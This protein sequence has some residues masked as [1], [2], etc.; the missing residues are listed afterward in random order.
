[1]R[2]LILIL[3]LSFPAF[4]LDFKEVQK[5][6]KANEDHLYQLY[7]DKCRSS[8]ESNIKSAAQSGEYYIHVLSPNSCYGLMLE[9][10]AADLILK[11]FKVKIDSAGLEGV[12]YEQILTVAW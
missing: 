9:E 12:H 3:L 11:G 5:M 4:G 2:K 8:I 10:I 1:M 7:R 6:T